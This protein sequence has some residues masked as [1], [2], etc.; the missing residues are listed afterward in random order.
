[1]WDATE[2]AYTPSPDR[3]DVFALKWSMVGN[4]VDLSFRNAEPHRADVWFWKACRTNPSGFADDKHQ[5]LA[6]RHAR[7]S[8]PVASKR[9]DTLYLQR[10]GDAGQPAYGEDIPFEYS[11]DWL[12]KY[13]PSVPEGSRADIRAKGVWAAGRWIIELERRLNTGHEDDLAFEAGSKY[14]FAASCYEMAATGHNPEWTQPLYRT[15]DAFDR[16]ILKVE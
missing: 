7:K 9:Y 16:L 10:R 15:G 13:R 6:R 12:P 3:E 11:K 8:L 14:L 2:E 1:M 4:D 5:I